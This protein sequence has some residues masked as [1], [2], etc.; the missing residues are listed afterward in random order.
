MTTEAHRALTRAC[1]TAGITSAED[2]AAR[3]GVR[4][5]A[6]SVTAA[7]TL[8]TTPAWVREVWLPTAGTTPVLYIPQAVRALARA[9]GITQD[10]G[11]SDHA[12]NHR[13][14]R[15]IADRRTP[16]HTAIR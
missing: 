5:A 1:R 3:F 4:R 7:L 2:F 9:Y 15:G 13:L 10:A 12:F 6:L 16:C 11:E 8:V 14:Q